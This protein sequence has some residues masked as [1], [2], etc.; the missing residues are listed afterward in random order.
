[1]LQCILVCSI[2]DVNEREKNKEN[3]EK[4]HFVALT[5][6]ISFKK[7]IEKFSVACAT[8]RVQF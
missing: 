1:M 5:G 4:K 8:A 2:Y 7:K 6:C 3:K